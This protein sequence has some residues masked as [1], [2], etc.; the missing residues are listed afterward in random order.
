MVFYNRP[1]TE[2]VRNGVEDSDSQQS[3]NW[4]NSEQRV[5]QLIEQF[6]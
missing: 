4:I 1:M 6:F 2:T 5:I 3:K